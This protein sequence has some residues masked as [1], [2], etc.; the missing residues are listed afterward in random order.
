MLVKF[1]QEIEH[2]L[3]D[4]RSA[5]PRATQFAMRTLR[6][7]YALAHDIARGDLTLRAMSLV[8]TTLL[9]VV[10]LLALVF[11]VLKG[12]GYHRDLEPV[13]YQFLEPMGDKGIEFTAQV[14]SFVENARGDVLGSLGV[15]FLLYTALSMVQKVEE[16]FNTVWRVAAPRSIARRISEYLGVLIVGPVLIIA[17]LGLMATLRSYRAVQAISQIEPFG[18]LLMWFGS[19]TP[20]VLV[21]CVFSFL[22]AFVPNTKVKLRAAVLGGVVA[23]FLWVGSGLLFASFVSGASNTML[24]YAG[25]AIVILT[26]IWLH[27][28]WLILLVGAQL[29]FYIQH[30]QCLRPGASAE[31]LTAALSERMALSIMYLVGED[32]IHADP[33]GTRQHFTL[34]TLSERL[35]LAATTL[36]PLIRRLEA[37]GLILVAEDDRLVPGRDLGA[38]ALTDILDAVRSDHGDHAMKHIRSVAAADA[39][40]TTATNAMRASLKETTLKELIDRQR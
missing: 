15:A 32:F 35:F 39:I 34:N 21:M 40:A 16:S 29:A 3:F 22:Y 18:T 19:V 28:S 10:P 7:P 9:S 12:L 17:A 1:L 4:N 36:A 24:I 13:L 5:A 8:Y 2:A 27:I 23:G 38:I 33:R 11:S 20:Y 26:L 37:S 6:Y 31:Q 30:P 14:M 25:F